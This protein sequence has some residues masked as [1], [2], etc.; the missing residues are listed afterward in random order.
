MSPLLAPDLA[1]IERALD[2]LL[3]KDPDA[4]VLAMRS[5]VRR[6]WP[7]CVVRRGRQYRV[8]WCSSELD[9]REQLDNAE[10]NGTD[11]VVVITPL[12]PTAL[13]DDVVARFPRARIEQS[14]RWSALRGAFRARDVDPRLRA[15]SWIADLLLERAPACGFPP[16][17]AGIIDLESAWRIVQK[18]V[19]GLPD[20]RVDASAL[21]EWTRDAANVDRFL[22]LDENAQNALEAR[23]AAEGG[24]AAGLVI[25]A[26]MKGRSGDALA[27]ALACGVVFGEAEPHQTLREAAV[28][29]EPIFGG[30]RV[31]ANAARDLAEAARRVLDRLARDEPPAATAIDARSANIL[32]EIRADTAAALSPA[33]QIG[34]DARIENAAA[35]IL[36]AVE[37][38]CTDDAAS[39]WDLTRHATRH[40]RAGDSSARL[41]RLV[42]AARLVQWLT[43]TPTSS[44]RTM[45]EAAAAYATE[46]GF[47]DRA[48]NAI[49]SGD[50]LPGAAATYARVSEAIT[51]RR[52]MENGAFAEVLRDWNSAGA[53]GEVPLPIE[54]VLT[55]VVAPLANQEPVLLLVLDGLT[56]AVWR[57]LA[58]TIGKLGWTELVRTPQSGPL[59][60]AAVLPSVTEVSRASLLC[61]ALTRGGQSDE[62]A[63]FAAHSDLVQA[64][65]VGHPP[66]LFHKADLGSGAELGSEVRAAVANPQQRIVGVVHN[67]VDAQLSGSDQ[68]ELRWTAESLRQIAALLYSA[69]DVGR[70][71]IVTGDHGHILD[72]GTMLLDGG[73]GD[74]WRPRSTPARDWEIEL[75]GGRVLTPSGGRSVIAAWSE[76][77]RFA[78]RRV[79]YHGGA[80]PQEVLVPLAVLSTGNVPP[81]GW[82]LAPPAEPAWWRGAK[83]E[84]I[85]LSPAAANTPSPPPRPRRA[86]LRQP[87]LFASEDRA[88]GSPNQREQVVAREAWLDDLFT[89]ETYAAQ[90]RLAGRG[91]PT[92]DQLRSLI[93]ALMTRGGRMTRAGLSQALGMPT[94][95]LT[96]LASAARRVLNLDQA[97]V[98]RDDGDDIVIDER[99]LKS[100]FILGDNR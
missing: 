87:D 44:W 57:A 96:G 59:L 43:G 27:A 77:V 80:S 63:G 66:R 23:V 49:R 28:R 94:F 14:D 61:G 38:G 21:L 1:Q 82:D 8:A 97:Q 40:D 9:L 22:N 78:V 42:M 46:G 91:A 99:L 7:D 24:P 19:L 29:L 12:D 51:A 100:Q 93:V 52:E 33:L 72:E 11:G 26:A 47:V 85:H 84:L 48:R 36:R 88:E 53:H 79:G 89:S 45:S 83:N 71:V 35:A 18:D 56:F 74:R 4:L 81:N 67:A 95:R 69:R 15:Q 20:G 68:L 30:V 86:G 31:D 58:E 76:R 60:A 2:N 32:A 65:R 50:P 98:L 62:R 64:S 73:S 39:A 5:P 6:A 34:L 41:E 3:Q 17:A 90:R 13:G 16:A 37:T 25:S 10:D 70:L 75:A 92:D 54:R 55:S